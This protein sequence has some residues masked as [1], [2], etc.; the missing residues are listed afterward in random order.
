MD[1]VGV[2]DHRPRPRVGVVPAQ[3]ALL[4]ASLLLDTRVEAA[5]CLAPPVAAARRPTNGP[6]TRRTPPPRPLAPLGRDDLARLASRRRRGRHRANNSRPDARPPL[7]ARS[8]LL[9]DPAP[10]A[11]RRPN[12]GALLRP[13]LG[14]QQDA[15]RVEGDKV[16]AERTAVVAVSDERANAS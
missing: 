14:R 16:G 7:L 10:R 2:T 11:P 15:K 1:V 4:L 9:L 12:A 6:E 13:G 8:E 5:P 3:T